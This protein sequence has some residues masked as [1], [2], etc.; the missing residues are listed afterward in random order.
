MERRIKLRELKDQNLDHYDRG[1]KGYYLG[2][3]GLER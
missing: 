2:G 3:T 1:L